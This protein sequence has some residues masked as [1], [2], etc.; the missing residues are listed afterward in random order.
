VQKQLPLE[1]RGGSGLGDSIYVQSVAM[2]MVNKGA[3]V[4]VRSNYADLFR[5]T[6]VNVVPF[7]RVG[8]CVI[9]HYASRKPEKTTQF[10]DVCINAGIREPVEMRLDWKAQSNLLDGFERPIVAVLL[11]RL[12][13]DRTDGYGKELMPRWEVLQKLIDLTDYTT[14]Q[15]GRGEP[16]YRYSGI[17]LDLSNKTSISQLLDVSSQVDG[18]VGTCSFMI[19]L[20][21]SLNK[22]FFALWSAKG[23]RSENDY[24]RTITPEKII[25]RKDLG[26]YA[27]DEAPEQNIQERYKLFLRQVTRQQIS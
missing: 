16:V 21:E 4:T 9:A 25:H 17:D 24:V 13:M 8:K 14:V 22:P 15:I 20:A 11:P 6:R 3:K 26:F 5:H 18:F 19:P 10:E 27:I 7:H 1:I 12:P 23:L 2:H